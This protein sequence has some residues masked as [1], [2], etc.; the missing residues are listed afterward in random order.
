MLDSTSVTHNF[1]TEK[2]VVALGVKVN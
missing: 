1:I 2:M